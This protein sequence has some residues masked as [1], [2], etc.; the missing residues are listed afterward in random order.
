MKGSTSITPTPMS[1]WPPHVGWDRVGLEAVDEIRSGETLA[2]SRDGVCN[3]GSEMPT[4]ASC[5]GGVW[6][7]IWHV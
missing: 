1:S 6:E 2:P 7:D 4:V 3:S 5:G